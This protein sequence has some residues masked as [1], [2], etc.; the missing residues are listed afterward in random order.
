MVIPGIRNGVKMVDETD[1]KAV[2]A[3]LKFAREQAGLTVKQASKV[4][5]LPANYI[6]NIEWSGNFTTQRVLQMCETYGVSPGWLLTGENP[7][8]DRQEA[9]DKLRANGASFEDANSIC[10]LLESLR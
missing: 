3:R 4:L 10:D 7:A 2:G 1:L 8:F 9:M 6:D 5:S